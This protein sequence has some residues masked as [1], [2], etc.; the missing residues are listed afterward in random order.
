MNA[1]LTGLREMRLFNMSPLLFLK[2]SKRSIKAN[3]DG[4]HLWFSRLYKIQAERKKEGRGRR[5]KG[6]KVNISITTNLHWNH[7]TANR[8]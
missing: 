7:Y 2:E 1:L 6:G 8:N 5:R 3:H 4:N